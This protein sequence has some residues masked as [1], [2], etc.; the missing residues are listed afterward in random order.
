MGTYQ[1][2][3]FAFF[4][5]KDPDNT[6][7][8]IVEVL[9]GQKFKEISRNLQDQGLVNRWWAINSLARIKGKDTAIKAGEYELTPGMS[10]KQILAK[11]IS[12]EVLKRLITI[13]EGMAISDIAKAVE[14]AKL[15][16][17]EEFK[18][19]ASNIDL[20]SKYGIKA[21][22]FE[23]YL[24]PESYQFSR[25]VTARQIIARM[26]EESDRRW[27]KEFGTR[28]DEMG[29]SRHEVITLA[30][31]IEKESGKVEEQPLIS[32]VFHNRIVQGM[33]LQAD[34]TVIYGLPNFNGNITEDNLKDPHPYN[35]Y[36]YSGLPPGPISNPGETAV[37][38]ALFPEQT[39]YLFFVADGT[40]GHV[41]STTLQEHNEAVR[42][43]Q[44]GKGADK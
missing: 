32:S 38:A 9:A 13:K 12:G 29:L 8:V 26:F 44:L 27:T 1:F 35:T 36:V 3:N 41:F 34:P 14:E 23:G 2:M 6:T 7:P 19:E 11:L 40:G 15:L 24:F 16:S 37:R 10:P 25:P 31:I 39:T 30:S 20:V 28:A 43:Y 22:S 18:K 17:A 42:I 21:K 4:K 5:A 33:R